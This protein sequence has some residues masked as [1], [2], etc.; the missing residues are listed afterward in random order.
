M[1]ELTSSPTLVLLPAEAAATIGTA[2]QH[3][4]AS[5]PPLCRARNPT[6]RKATSIKLWP[7]A[8]YDEEH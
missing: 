3:C 6:A 5:T 2:V 7:Q 1:V 4:K 8:L